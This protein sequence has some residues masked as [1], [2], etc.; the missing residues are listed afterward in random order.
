[1]DRRE[2]LRVLAIAAAAGMKPAGAFGAGADAGAG[3]AAS[4][5]DVEAFGNARLLHFT[6]CHAQL[7]PIYFREPN[8][9]LGIGPMRGQR[10]HVVGEA[11]LREAGIAPGS[12]RAHAF[13]YLD[14]EA[15]ARRYGAVGGG[16]HL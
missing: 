15:A 9:N 4:L 12:A 7:N 3:D 11:L 16:A 1:M 13:T 8:V 14:F 10:P 2:F 6:D 5:Y